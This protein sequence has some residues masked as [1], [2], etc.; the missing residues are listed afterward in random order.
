M[1]IKIFEVRDRCTR[2]D[3][4]AIRM[5]SADPTE[6]SYLRRAGFWAGPGATHEQ[7]T[8][9]VVVVR[10]ADQ[11]A[12]SDP[13]EWLAITGDRI[14]LP[15]AHKHIIKCWCQLPSGSVVDAEHLRGETPEPKRPEREHERERERE[16]EVEE[17][18]FE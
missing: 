14:T 17:E 11:K 9:S 12:T 6:W 8:Y 5:R 10:L 13:Y 16:C 7:Y 15:T 3:V 4:M 2:I 1:D 18:D